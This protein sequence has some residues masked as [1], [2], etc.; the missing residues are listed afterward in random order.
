MFGFVLQAILGLLTF[1]KSAPRSVLAVTWRS[2]SRKGLTARSF[3]IR[4]VLLSALTL[5]PAVGCSSLSGVGTTLS[6]TISSPL[7][8][9]GEWSAGLKVSSPV[10]TTETSGR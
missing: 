7:E 2:T 6:V 1:R 3:V 9:G 8:G 5:F 4:L 10:P